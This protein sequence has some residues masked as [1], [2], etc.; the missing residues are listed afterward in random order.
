VVAPWPDREKAGRDPV[1]EDQFASAM[2][3]VT[4]IR[5]FRKA[6]EIRDSMSLSAQVYPDAEYRGVF[7]SLRPEIERL[8]RLSTLDLLA[9]AGDPA[10][11][12]RLVAPH[13]QVLIPLA[14]VLDP[15]VERERL[16][17]RLASI[18]ADSAKV[19]TKLANPQ[20]VSNAPAE[21]VEKERARLRA[22]Q[23]EQAALD[24]Q[25]EELG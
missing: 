6:H 12:A 10:G 19:S 2:D 7:E 4:A 22:F 15:E 9:E 3:L 25:L 17:G 14:G 16:R 13:A 11:C 18:E 23:E 24:A 21:I 5:R 20:F 1:S 8:A